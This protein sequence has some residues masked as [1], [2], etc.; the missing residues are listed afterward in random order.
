MTRAARLAAFV[1]WWLRRAWLFPLAV[2]AALVV[3]TALQSTR[4]TSA[5]VVVLLDPILVEELFEAP[6]TEHDREA[7]LREVGRFLRGPEVTAEATTTIGDLVDVSSSG[8][9]ETGQITITVD[10]G[11]PGSSAD[12]AAVVAQVFLEQRRQV[13]I[14]QAEAGIEAVEADV[15]RLQVEREQVVD[16]D[17][18]DTID[19]QLRDR[20]AS[21]DQ[22]SS[23]LERLEQ[24]DSTGVLVSGPVRPQH[25]LA[26]PL[27]LGSFV[28]VLVG[29]TVLLR[30]RWL[31]HDAPVGRGWAP[32]AEA[33]VADAG[34]LD[35][36]LATLRVLAREGGHPSL[37]VCE[38]G[39]PGSARDLGLALA[40]RS[41]VER[42]T[43]VLDG[44]LAGSGQ[45]EAQAVGGV[46]VVAG[47]DVRALLA[48]PAPSLPTLPEGSWPAMVPAGPEV[49]DPS[50]VVGAG[51]ARLLAAAGAVAE[52]VIVLGPPA[53]G[54]AAVAWGARAGATVLVGVEG[55]T[56]AGQLDEGR[57][58]LGRYGVE[59][60]LVLVDPAAVADAGEGDGPAEGA[61]LAER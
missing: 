29:G 30:V 20:Q 60:V 5:Q 36:A 15:E 34:D 59:S 7:D 45:P 17:Q 39:R 8:D 43:L 11:D 3:G 32:A 37:V 21:I 52:L 33:R 13:A 44:D 6:G 46:E 48:D 18:L 57:A 23:A 47:T 10:R 4:P 56:T 50:G 31:R 9:P 19:T 26:T 22:L 28:L 51:G 58:W 49:D 40:R 2:V 35:A 24:P 61:L 1:R 54:L 41:A 53:S 16:V 12:A 38:G 55:E 14:A 42:P 25:D 27:F